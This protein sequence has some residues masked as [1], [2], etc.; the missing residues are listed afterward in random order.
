[1]NSK[2]ALNIAFYG[3]HIA[4]YIIVSITLLNT[5]TKRN[6]NY[7]IIQNGN[8]TLITQLHTKNYV[9]YYIIALFVFGRKNYIIA[10]VTIE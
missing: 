2:I 8:N 7:Q 3:V 10:N 1:M 6:F 5:V 4:H 9:Y